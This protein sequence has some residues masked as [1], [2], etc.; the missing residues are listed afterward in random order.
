MRKLFRKF[1]RVVNAG[2]KNKLDESAL[3]ELRKWGREKLLQNDQV[4]EEYLN[5]RQV[6]HDYTNLLSS[7][8]EKSEEDK[9]E[10]VANYVGLT[11]TAPKDG[12]STHVNT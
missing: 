3:L 7:N 4:L 2:E 6:L 11:T 10:K 8:E 12:K 1:L 5:Y 9:I